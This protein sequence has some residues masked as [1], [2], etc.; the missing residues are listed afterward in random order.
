M[1]DSEYLYLI[2]LANADEA[3]SA[4]KAR[5]TAAW[6][7]LLRSAP[8]TYDAVYAEAKAFDRTN[9]R[10][11]RAY[12]V[13]AD[14]ADAVAAALTASGVEVVPLDP[15]DVYSKY[16]ASGGEWFQLAH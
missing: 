7:Q 16:E 13:E 2:L 1:A 8:D 14:A 12:M 11:S 6:T 4:F 15:D 3:E 10:V 9:G 5:L